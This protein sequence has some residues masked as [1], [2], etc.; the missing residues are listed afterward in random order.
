VAIEEAQGEHS[1]L[2]AALQFV[3]ES[4]DDDDNGEG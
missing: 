4:E 3:D 2:W 1:E